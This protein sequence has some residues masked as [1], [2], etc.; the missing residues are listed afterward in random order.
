MVSTW[1]TVGPLDSLKARGVRAFE[2]GVVSIAVFMV[3]GAPYAIESWSTHAGE[4]LQ[5]GAVDGFTIVCP[6]HGACFDLRT[7]ALLEPPAREPLHTYPVRIREGQVEVEI[8]R[9]EIGDH[10]GTGPLSVD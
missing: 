9:A 1:Q 2:Q 7:G 8:V 4:D 3:E 6:W 5:E 10:K